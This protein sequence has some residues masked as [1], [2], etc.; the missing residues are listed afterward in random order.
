MIILPGWLIMMALALPVLTIVFLVLALVVSYVHSTYVMYKTNKYKNYFAEWTQA[1]NCTATIPVLV[2][3]FCT[4]AGL[5]AGVD[6][7]HFAMAL[8]YGIANFTCLLYW[9]FVVD[10]YVLKHKGMLG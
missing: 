10:Y 4:I 3:F 6:P 8:W 5:I 1:Y 7:G 2:S 9:F